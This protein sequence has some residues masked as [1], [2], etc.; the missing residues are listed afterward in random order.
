MARERGASRFYKSHRACNLAEGLVQYR[1]QKFISRVF[2]QYRWVTAHFIN[3]QNSYA[4]LSVQFLVG[5]LHIN[6]QWSRGE[7]VLL[8][9]TFWIV[10]LN[11]RTLNNLR[12]IEP[13]RI[14]KTPLR[15]GSLWGINLPSEV[16]DYSN[17]SFVLPVR[18]H[19][20]FQLRVLH[21]FGCY[22]KTKTYKQPR[23]CSIPPCPREEKVAVR[24]DE[25]WPDART[26]QRI[27]IVL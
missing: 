23:L 21:F 24:F 13:T 11:L 17:E 18:R 22:K 16:W 2:Y 5:S 7:N 8:E 4:F 1:K 19:G 6:C 9:M 25:S 26:G 14:K 3:E 27:T 15:F 20:T 12:H 10:I